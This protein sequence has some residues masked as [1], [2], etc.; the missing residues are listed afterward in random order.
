MGFAH[1]LKVEQFTT[2]FWGWFFIS[3]DRMG[4]CPQILEFEIELASHPGVGSGIVDLGWSQPGLGPVTDLRPFGNTKSQQTS[5]QVAQ[6]MIL[7]TR[8][9]GQISDIHKATRLKHSDLVEFLDV[10]IQGHPRL[11][12][13]RIGQ[14]TTQ[15]STKVTLFDLKNNTASRL[16]S[17]K[18]RGLIVRPLRKV[19]RV[20]VSKPNKVSCSKCSRAAATWSGLRITWIGPS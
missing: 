4:L 19:G 14:E 11:N 9:L 7:A 5:S 12:N 10:T 3:S 17:C 8:G 15:T 16:A 2:P 13:I 6:A 18:T 20:S 1:R